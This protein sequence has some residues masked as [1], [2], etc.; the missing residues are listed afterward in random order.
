MDGGLDMDNED[1]C[2]ILEEISGLFDTVQHIN[3]NKYLLDHLEYGF[4]GTTGDRFYGL[5]PRLL[6]NCK[7][8]NAKSAFLALVDTDRFRQLTEYSNVDQDIEYMKST[9]EKEHSLASIR[10][11]AS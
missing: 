3:E 5:V 2:D 6:E 9:I 11:C 8:Y 10:K 1:T 7:D 4:K